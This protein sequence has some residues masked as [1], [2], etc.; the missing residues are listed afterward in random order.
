MTALDVIR[1][2]EALGG[3]LKVD[4][5][6]LLVRTPRPLPPRLLSVVRAEKLAI[7]TALGTPVDETVLSVLSELRPNLPMAL[8]GLSNDQLLLVIN[9][10][11][12]QAWGKS[13]SRLTDGGKQRP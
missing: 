12:M 10:G 4:D 8:R 5:G 3:N 7:M 13:V 6:R 9:Y 11:I 1:E 2:I